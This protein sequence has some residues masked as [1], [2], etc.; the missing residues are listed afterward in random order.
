MTVNKITMWLAACFLLVA[1]SATVDAQISLLQDD[2]FCGDCCEHDLQFFA[3]VDF[4]FECQPISRRC[5]WYFAFD[6]ISWAMTGERTQLGDPTLNVQS[7]VVL[8]Q[9]ANS[10]GVA[11]PTYQIINSVQD[12]P[13]GSEFGWGERYEFGRMDNGSGWLLGIL[14]GPEINTTEVYGFNELTIPGTLPLITRTNNDNNPTTLFDI[15][16]I[17][18]GLAALLFPFGPNDVSTSINGFGSVHVNFATPAG[19]LLGLRDYSVNG[20]NNELGPTIG[21]PSRVIVATTVETEEINGVLTQNQITEAALVTGADINPDDL[22]GDGL[23]FFF[24]FI[25]VDASGDFNDGDIFVGNGVDFDDLH[26]FNI[27]FDTVIARN[28]TETQGF[29]LMRT[30]DLDNSHK[31]KKFQNS[32]A[33]VAYGVRY[34]RLRDEFYFEG[35]GGFTGLTYFDTEAQNSIVG[36]QIRGQWHT[37]NGRWGFD[38]DGRFTFGYNVQDMDQIGAVAQDFAPGALNRSATGQPNA[39]RSGSH[40]ETFA[41]VVEFRA[42]ASYKITNS[43][44][45]RLGYTAIFIDNI[46]RSSQIVRW[47]LPD[48]GLLEGGQQDIFINGVNFGFDLTY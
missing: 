4:D 10:E 9:T 23:T 14:D 12:A 26:T 44:N 15:D 37:Q 1:Q 46:T 33:S 24:V 3:P 25:D 32:R 39:V 6:K 17:D 13:P 34:L 45:A 48:V 47:A 16:D 28:I 5:G 18:P 20:P 8:T 27:A 7:E 41:P 36:P 43:I 19:Y 29:E 2:E 22:D 35:R 11:P 30:V 42:D 40:E 31:M 38:I 21:G